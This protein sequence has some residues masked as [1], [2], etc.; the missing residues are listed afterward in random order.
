[1][2]LVPLNTEN[3]ARFIAAIPSWSLLLPVLKIIYR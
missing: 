2:K 3:V 1:M